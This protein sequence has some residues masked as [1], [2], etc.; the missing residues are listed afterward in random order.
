M[1]QQ[2]IS[3]VFWGELDYL[4]IDT[5]PGIFLFLFFFFFLQKK[6]IEISIFLIGTSDEH[7]S[8]AELLTDFNP[9]GVVLVTTPQVDFSFFFNFFFFKFSALSTN[10]IRELHFQM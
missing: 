9:D 6:R 8:I 4:I 1:I 5:P 2:F 7:I 3:N 10:F